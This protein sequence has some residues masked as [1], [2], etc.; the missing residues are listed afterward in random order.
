MPVI[1]YKAKVENVYNMDET[2]AYQIVKV[3]AKITSA[4]YSREDWRKHPKFGSYV[5]SDLFP[6]LVSRQLSL[7]NVKLGTNIRLDR[8]PD[9]V[10]VDTTGFLAVVTINVQ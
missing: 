10:T 7:L 1:S 9:A 4:H 6:N 5:N 3:P 2:L 8:L